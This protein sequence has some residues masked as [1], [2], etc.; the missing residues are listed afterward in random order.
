MTF[1]IIVAFSITFFINSSPLLWYTFNM[2]D[3]L[4][5]Q[6]NNLVEVTLARGLEEAIQKARQSGNP[7][8]I[9]AF[10]DALVDTLHKKLV[11]EG[12]IAQPK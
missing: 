3:D 12:K 10:H 2:A 11:A 1:P 6:V 5:T 4:V 8:L 7:A 9:D